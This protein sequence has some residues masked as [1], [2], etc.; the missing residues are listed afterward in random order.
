MKKLRP[1]LFFLLAGMVWLLTCSD[2]GPAY[3]NAYTPVFMERSELER[4]VF[5][6]EGFREMEQPGK[7]WVSDERIFVNDKYKGVHI[8]DNSTPASPRQIGFIMAPGCLDMAV[9]GEIIY[10]DNAVDLVA[11]DMA[12]G[13]VTERLKNYFPP[14]TKPDGSRFYDPTDLIV[15][16]WKNID[17][18]F[19]DE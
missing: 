13:K 3:Y 1:L 14:L 11:F 10:L 8:I 9:R 12:T 19:K 4:S 17:P 16:E 15:V 2:I 7:I 6:V 18:K 5:F